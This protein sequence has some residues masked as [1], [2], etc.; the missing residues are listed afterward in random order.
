MNVAIV[1]LN[2]NGKVLL[3][4]FLPSV[5]VHSQG[6]TVYVA[7]NASSDDS[8]AYVK[9]NFPSVQIIQN[10][11]NGGYAK[12][13]NDALRQL[14]EDL[15]VLLNNDVEITKNWLTPILSAFKED[16]K[17]VAAQPKILDYKNK[18]Y[19]EYAGA[20]GGFI[21]KLGYP[22][23]RGRIFDTLEKDEGQYNDTIPI[24][25]A[26]GACLFVK[27]DNFWNVGGFD[28]DLF[29]H[30][31]EIDLCWRLQSVGGII[32]YLG[33]S[34]VFHLGGAT[35]SKANPQ[36]TFFN[37]RNTLLVLLKN[38]KG[39]IVY[40]LLFIRLLLDGM[41]ALQFLLQGKWTHI[42]AIFK[43]HISFYKWLP[44][45]LQKRKEYASAHPY[46][47][48]NSI[49]HKYFIQKKRTFNNL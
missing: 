5:V 18:N 48:V 9:Q 8:V 10:T 27:Q 40:V 19:F 11:V 29:A 49:V 16:P 1:I 39:S 3:E 47:K 23:C 6:A 7:D 46:G 12:G 37:F 43:A 21:D 15:F 13:Y 31:E 28:E 42:W 4:Q 33:A 34:T 24:F 36:K 30:Q 38:R 44:K 22:F 2:W 17:L 41:A 26:S 20:A 25:W 45:F 14:T 35:L 32:K